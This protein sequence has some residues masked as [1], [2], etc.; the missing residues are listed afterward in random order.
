FG[1]S[2]D[3]NGEHFSLYTENGAELSQE[4]LLALQLVACFNGTARIGLPV[5]APMELESLARLI[6]VEVV[7]TKVTPRAMMEVSTH[8]LFHPL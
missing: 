3:K 5:S 6:N 4:Q 8:D 7:R 1:I 2:L